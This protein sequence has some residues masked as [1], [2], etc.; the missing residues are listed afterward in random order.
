MRVTLHIADTLSREAG[1]PP[2]IWAK[3]EGGRICSLLYTSLPGRQHFASSLL[4]PE[5]SLVLRYPSLGTSTSV[6]SLQPH[7][8]FL[9][10]PSLANK[11][12]SLYFSNS[13]TAGAEPC[14]KSYGYELPKEVGYCEKETR[15]HKDSYAEIQKHSQMP[16]WLGLWMIEIP[17]AIAKTSVSCAGLLKFISASVSV[18]CPVTMTASV[19]LPCCYDKNTWQKW[20]KK[21]RFYFCSHRSQYCP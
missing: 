3:E 12:G 18:T 4:A 9:S 11:D 21:G 1:H 5:L 17:E 16:Y 13:R 7:S 19:H 8:W 15:L 14:N 20:V 2:V 10:P 6:H